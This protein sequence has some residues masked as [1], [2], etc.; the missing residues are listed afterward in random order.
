LGIF[1][2]TQGEY[3]R[4]AGEVAS[5]AIACVPGWGTA[6]SVVLDVAIAGD[7]IYEGITREPIQPVLNITL[8]GAY[9]LLGI[10]SID[11]PPTQAAVE[12]AYRAQIQLVHPDT[13]GQF[14]EFFA[15]QGNEM[16][17][18][19]NAARDF[20]FAERQWR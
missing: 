8:P 9:R 19:I 2:A 5:G 20:I 16:T 10:E 7:D 17:E 13:L 11:P 6:A 15:Q 14:G 12:R 4:A 3:W 1:R 18:A